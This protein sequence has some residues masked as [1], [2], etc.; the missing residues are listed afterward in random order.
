M[1]RNNRR[2]NRFSV[3]LGIALL[4]GAQFL[5]NPKAE[6]YSILTHEQVVDIVWKD[7]LEPA[8]KARFSDA[9][10]KALR[11]AHAFA[12]GGCLIQDMGYYPFG[13]KLFSDLTHYVRSGDFVGNLLRDATNLNE[14]AFA[15]GS[16]AHYCSDTDGHPVV[17]Q[18]VAL[19]FPKLRARHGKEVTY[20]QDPKAHIRVEF[21]FDVVQVAKNHYSSEQYH[22]F[23]GF[24]VAQELLERSFLKTYGVKLNEV[25]K[26]EDVAIGTFRH[27]VSEIMPEM[28]RVALLERRGD[29]EKSMTN[30]NAKSFRYRMTP[31]EYKKDFGTVYRKPGIFSRSLSWFMRVVPKV[32]PFKAL[33]F[34]VPN[35]EGEKLYLAS[36][37]KTCADFRLRIKQARAGS[38]QL[39][40]F[41][42]DTGKVPKLGEYHLADKTYSDLLDKHAKGK[43]ERV[44]PDLRANLLAFFNGEHPP[45]RSRKEKKQWNKTQMELAQLRAS[46]TPK[47][48]A[49]TNI[50]EKPNPASPA[51]P[52]KGSTGNK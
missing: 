32:G 21:G 44:T 5:G 23:I 42:F 10:E 46:P 7:S 24:E 27:A 4:V 35:P 18:V 3:G 16:L 28:V 9:D 50:N 19:S 13:N 31:A 22:D 12:Y 2:E 25:L 40:N 43:F 6:A 29:L 49:Q 52:P 36:L 14:Y 47:Q 11:K 45:A 41:D 30:F 33:A 15:L 37:D 26:L 1:P 8:L 34:K 39:S 48:L 38:L 51:Y 20:E 17:N